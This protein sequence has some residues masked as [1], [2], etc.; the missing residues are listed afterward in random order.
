MT[1]E[2]FIKHN[3]GILK[4]INGGEEVLNYLEELKDLREKYKN[5]SEAFMRVNNSIF[6]TKMDLNKVSQENEHLRVELEK[7]SKELEVYK[8]AILLLADHYCSNMSYAVLP[9]KDYV[10]CF[11]QKAREDKE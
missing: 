7:N 6:D 11:I 1:L 3:K 4:Q 10:D 9:P 8:R 5:V 2:E